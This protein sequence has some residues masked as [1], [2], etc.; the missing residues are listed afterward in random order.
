MWY[1]LRRIK[2][3][4]TITQKEL[5]QHKKGQKFAQNPTQGGAK[6]FD[7]LKLS[8]AMST[9]VRF[10]LRLAHRYDACVRRK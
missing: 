2:R 8:V 4:R 10:C 5:T 3:S 1:S 9:L 6:C 7:I